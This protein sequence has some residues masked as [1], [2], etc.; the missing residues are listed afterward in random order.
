MFAMRPTAVVDIAAVAA[1]HVAVAAAIGM[2]CRGSGV[3][4]ELE[5]IAAVC[6]SCSHRLGCKLN[7]GFG[8]KM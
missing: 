4:A 3:F 8:K 6:S 2:M 5:P 7:S 1:V